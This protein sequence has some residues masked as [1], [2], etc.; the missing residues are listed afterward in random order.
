MGLKN[1]EKM[2]HYICIDQKKSAEFFSQYGRELIVNISKAAAD[3]M[4]EDCGKLGLVV[5]YDDPSLSDFYQFRLRR[6]AKYLHVDLRA[7]L[8]ELKI[9]N[10]GGHP[11]A[12]GFRVLKDSVPDIERYTAGIVSRIE[13]LVGEMAG[14]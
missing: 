11:G 9:E 2:I 5:Y 8:K 14:C 4:A 1:A 12:I 6:S 7:V 3:T 10:G 13:T